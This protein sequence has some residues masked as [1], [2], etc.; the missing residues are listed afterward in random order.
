[1]WTT[2]ILVSL[3]LI[4]FIYSFILKKPKYRYHPLYIT[5]IA[6][7]TLYFLYRIVDEGGSVGNIFVAL[8]GITILIEQFT[9]YK[10]NAR[11]RI[12]SGGENHLS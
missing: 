8:V 1:M 2:I 6:F 9:S 10:K 4:G 7:L 5:L 12:S 3:L 11:E